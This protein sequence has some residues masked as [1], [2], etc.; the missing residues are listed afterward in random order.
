MKIVFGGTFDPPHRGHL[1]C[2][3]RALA[4]FPAAQVLVVPARVPGAVSGLEKTPGASFTQRVVMCRLLIQA[5][6][7]AE[8]KRVAI[9]TIEEKLPVPNYT[10]T[11]LEALK[12]NDVVLLLGEDQLAGFAVAVVD[13]T[14]C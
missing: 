12:N 2:I 5:L 11:T 8:R 3:V 7:E 4:C 1:A 10:V 14:S 6:S 9:S 13:L